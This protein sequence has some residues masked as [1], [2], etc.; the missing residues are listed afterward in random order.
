MSTSA[1]LGQK[2][3]RGTGRMAAVRELVQMLRMLFEVEREFVRTVSAL[4][5]RVG[6]IELKYLVCQH[7]WESVSHARFLRERG[8]ELSGFGKD[9]AVRESYRSIF[10]EAIR[11]EDPMIFVNRYWF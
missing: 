2:P 6:N 3:T 4:I 5:P 10:E 7:I 11:A 1:S 8:G 9:D